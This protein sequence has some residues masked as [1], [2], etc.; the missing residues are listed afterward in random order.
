MK[1]DLISKKATSAI[2]GTVMISGACVFW[3]CYKRRIEREI[4]EFDRIM[5]E[6]K[7]NAVK[8]YNLPGQEQELERK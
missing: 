2:M 1:K 8:Q 3:K 4:D 5:H 6:M 7:V